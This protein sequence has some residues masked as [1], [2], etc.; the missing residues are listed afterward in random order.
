[1]ICA[2]ETCLEDAMR[3]KLHQHHDLWTNMASKEPP[4]PVQVYNLAVIVANGRHPLSKLVPPA[5]LAADVLLCALIIWKVPCKQ[6][7]PTPQ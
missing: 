3:V 5:L 1:M 2:T 6:P 7:F 4:F